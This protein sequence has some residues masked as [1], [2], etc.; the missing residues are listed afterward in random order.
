MTNRWVINASP[1]ILL[2]KAGQL[3]C[4]PRL[5]KVVVPSPDHQEA[6]LAGHAHVNPPNMAKSSKFSVSSELTPAVR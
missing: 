3:G 4:V 2:G 1:L 5:G 6:E